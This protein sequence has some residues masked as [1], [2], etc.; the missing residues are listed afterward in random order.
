M[1]ARELR[2][3]WFE[4]LLAKENCCKIA[5]A[6]NLNDGIE[7]LLMNIVHAQGWEGMSGIKASRGNRIRPLLF[8]SRKEIAEY[9]L[10]NKIQ[11]KEDASNASLKYERNYVRHKIIP[12]LKQLNPSLEK[13][14]A[15]FQYKINSASYFLRYGIEQ[16]KEK[17]TVEK[18][19]DLYIAKNDLD[20]SSLWILLQ[21]FGFNVSQ[22]RQLADVKEAQVGKFFQSDT[23]IVVIDRQYLSVKKIRRQEPPPIE[24]NEGRAARGKFALTIRQAEQR[25][26]SGAVY[27]DF[28]KLK[29]PLVWRTWKKG[30]FFY[31]SGM[32]HRK[33]ISDFLI[34]NKIPRADKGDISVLESNGNIVWVVGMRLDN[35]F[36]ASPQTKRMLE[37]ELTDFS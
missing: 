26:E 35:R 10:E 1:A 2:Y 28:D 9:A 12:E 36:K 13:T 29:F 33:K 32:E 14:F 19:D 21:P 27:L 24:V 16:W 25:K 17:F 23:H 31:P 4:E 3:Q 22:V 6:H 30:D 11:W 37:I 7:T 34:D 20:P 8:A 5:T 18:G 15:D